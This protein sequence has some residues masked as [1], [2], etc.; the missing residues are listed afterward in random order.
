MNDYMNDFDWK[1]GIV[2]G[3]AFLSAMFII[4]VSL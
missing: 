3:L 4:G 2:Y 1:K